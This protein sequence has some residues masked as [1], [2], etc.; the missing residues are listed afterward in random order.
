MSGA[1][2]LPADVERRA[3]PCCIGY[4][5][6]KGDCVGNSTHRGCYN[7]GNS[8]MGGCCAVPPVMLRRETISRWVLSNWRHVFE[9]YF[10]TFNCITCRERRVTARLLIAAM[11]VSN[12]MIRWICGFSF[13][14]SSEQHM[15]TVLFAWGSSSNRCG[16]GNIKFSATL[17]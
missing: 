14:C 8:T 3:S 6:T 11:F 2:S 4:S 13:I 1:S 17:T 9:D 12:F 10:F 15:R 5:W 16:T 7:A